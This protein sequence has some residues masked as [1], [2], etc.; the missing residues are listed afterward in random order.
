MREHGIQ[1]KG[2]RNKYLETGKVM[3]KELIESLM[4]IST[5]AHGEQYKVCRDALE[6]SNGDVA[7]DEWP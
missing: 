6:L 4:D 1:D 3:L 5:F 7:A 2:A